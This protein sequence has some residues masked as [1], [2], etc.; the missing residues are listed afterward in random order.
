LQPALPNFR[1]QKLPA[2]LR[3]TQ[4][5]RRLE[6]I[7]VGVGTGT[8]TGTDGGPDSGGAMNTVGMGS[9]AT[10]LVGSGMGVAYGS[11]GG[12]RVPG[13]SSWEHDA[14]LD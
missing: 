14:R 6:G 7:G 5:L 1:Q 3:G 8:G 10:L 2:L 11:S 4:I 12:Y 9:K 13:V